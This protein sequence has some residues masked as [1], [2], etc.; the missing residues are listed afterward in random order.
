MGSL[1]MCCIS[2]ASCKILKSFLQ[3]SKMQPATHKSAQDAQNNLVGR[4]PESSPKGVNCGSKGSLMRGGS[5]CCGGMNCGG[6]YIPNQPGGAITGAQPCN[7]KCTTPV[8]K[9]R[10]YIVVGN[11]D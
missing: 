1:H 7:R 5:T 3:N 10:N 8:Q 9:G 6:P 2:S 4:V 11:E